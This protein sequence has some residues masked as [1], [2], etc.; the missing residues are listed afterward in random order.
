MK[1]KVAY[2]RGLADGMNIG[3]ADDNNS[4]LLNAIIDCLDSMAA[5]VDENTETIDILDEEM[6]DVFESIDII[7]EALFEDEDD[8]DFDDDFDHF[9]CPHCGEIV[10]L[11]DEA[12]DD[13]ANPICTKCNMPL[14]D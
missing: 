14:F 9:T 10:A 3:A 7:D 13:Q 11:D 6:D 4:R 8:A 12:L 1:S 5:Q 2:L